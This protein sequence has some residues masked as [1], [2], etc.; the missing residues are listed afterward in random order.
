MRIWWPITPD[1]G[2]AARGAGLSVCAIR[3]TTA[4]RG[5]SP[6]WIVPCGLVTEQS[7][8]TMKQLGGNGPGNPSK[9]F[10]ARQRRRASS[11]A[12]GSTGGAFR[13]QNRG[14][15]VACLVGRSKAEKSAEQG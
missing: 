15:P 2:E 11:F 7:N 4:C 14:L 8:G 10:C 6:S 5:A 1:A 13:E 12:S 9:E 3:M